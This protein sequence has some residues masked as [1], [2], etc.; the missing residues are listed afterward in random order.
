MSASRPVGWH[1]GIDTSWL[2]W[3]SARVECTARRSRRVPP[4]AGARTR[5]PRTGPATHDRVRFSLRGRTTRAHCSH[6]H[7]VRTAAAHRARDPT[8]DGLAHVRQSQRQPPCLDTA[9][10]PRDGDDARATLR[11]ETAPSARESSHE[12]WAR[13]GSHTQ[14]SERCSFSSTSQRASER[15]RRVDEEGVALLFL[16][17]NVANPF[18][19]TSPTDMCVYWT[20]RAVTVKRAR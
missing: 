20:T 19:P 12:P 11:R 2:V 16:P 18:Q 5:C 3:W 6:A 8:A 10:Q 1:R 7:N 9:C 17:G 4:R 14:T 13:S 15:A